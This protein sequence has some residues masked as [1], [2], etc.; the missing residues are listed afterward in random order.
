M[1]RLTEAIAVDAIGENGDRDRLVVSVVVNWNRPELTLEAMRA[2]SALAVPAGVAHRLVLVDNGSTDGSLARLRPAMPEAEILELPANVGFA[3]GANAGVLRALDMGADYTMLVNNDTVAE[4]GL[5]EQLVSAVEADPSIGMAVPTVT[6]FDSPE[7]VWPSAGRRRRLT[8][9][10]VDTTASPPSDA[11]YDVAWAVGCC[12]LVK[13]DTWR[14]IGL[15]DT[16]FRMYYED[17]DLC[18]RALEAG[19]RIVH[20]PAARI[21]HRV[22][23]STGPGSPEQAYLL[24]RSSVPYFWTHSRGVHRAFLIA[25]R[26]LSLTRRVIEAAVRRQP[27]FA[28]AHLAG[29]RDGI[30]D[31]RRGGSRPMIP[32]VSRPASPGGAPSTS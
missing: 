31:L 6:Y 23:A 10:A 15:F 32:R 12:M 29:V 5:L 22:A 30:G 11:P 18:I 16:R 9:A 20:V 24:A 19:W 2:L 25:Y 1:T 14:S 21:R 8:L 7:R 4:P 3:R 28:R 17:H 13:R 26:A 27:A